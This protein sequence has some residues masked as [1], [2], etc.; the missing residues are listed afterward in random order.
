MFKLYRVI[1]K[2]KKR[3][4]KEVLVI[5]SSFDSAANAAQ[6]E[7]MEYTI[8]SVSLE[9]KFIDTRQSN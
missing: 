9:G 7:A 5:A 4:Y 1:L 6:S 8:N 2:V 3:R